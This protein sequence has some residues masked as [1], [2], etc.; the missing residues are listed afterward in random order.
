MG[1]RGLFLDI[2]N[3]SITASYLIVAVMLARFLLKKAPKSVYCVLWLFVG[4]RLIMPFSI[5]SAFSLIPSGLAINMEIMA[6]NEKPVLGTDFRSN[7]SY[8]S[9]EAILTIGNDNHAV[10]SVNKPFVYLSI[11]TVGWLLGIGIM[12]LYLLI[13]W[14]QLAKRV[15]MAVPAEHE[16]IKYYQ[17]DTIDSPFLFGLF[18]PRIYV[19]SGLEKGELSY[20]L[21]HE[22][23]HRQRRDYLIKPIGYALLTVYWFNPFIWA[24]YILLCRDIELSCDE[25]VIRELGEEH[26]QEYSRALLACAVRHRTIAACPVAFG[27]TGVKRRVKN[28]LSY[29]RPAFWVIIAAVLACA[30]IAVCFMTEQR[31]DDKQN[32]TENVVTGEISELLGMETDDNGVKWYRVKTV[33]G[34]EGYVRADM[35]DAGQLAEAPKQQ[36]SK[37]DKVTELEAE[38]KEIRSQMQ[39]T[40]TA[41]AESSLELNSYNEFAAQWAEAFCSRNGEAVMELSDEAA[42]S[43]LEELGL[44]EQGVD[45]NNEPYASF[46]WSSS[47]PWGGDY[48]IISASDSMAVILYYAWVSDPHLTVWRQEI[49]YKAEKDSFKVTSQHTKYYDAIC[50]A[51]E[52]YKAYPDGAID[53][54]MMD[55]YQY[56]E[57]GEIL[58]ANAKREDASQY[59]YEGLDAPDTAAVRLLN[60]LDNENK[61]N[62]TVEYT[63]EE[64]TDAVVTFTFMEDMSTAKVRMIKPYGDD[65]IWLP[66][67]YAGN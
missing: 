46:G 21:R 60:I 18:R 8:I 23:A 43:N 58:N 34:E 9:E 62:T 53:G 61:V 47:W 3:L 14:C 13:S 31:D 38:I 6:D 25:K 44:L 27:E 5:V 48:R 64:K 26:K 42:I 52:F 67:T 37:S 36:A 2:F 55:Y 22:A 65:S 20:V 54:T 45:E 51:E 57:A 30:V 7:K 49:F 11:V 40:D 29:K 35:H 66:Q 41:E 56:N 17:C 39:E 10:E 63:N 33:S 4:I 15:R 32:I 28:I 16:G 50:V 24:A 19:P 59:A 1:I 12:L